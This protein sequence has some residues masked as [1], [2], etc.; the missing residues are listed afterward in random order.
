MRSDLRDTEGESRAQLRRK[1]DVLMPLCGADDVGRSAHS[2]R[3]RVDRAASTAAGS[4][5]QASR[6]TR[7]WNRWSGVARRTPTEEPPGRLVRPAPDGASR[8][9]AESSPFLMSWLIC[10]ARSPTVARRSASRT[11]AVLVRRRAARSPRSRDNVPT[12]SLPPSNSNVEAIEI[13]HRR[14]LG[15]IGQRPADA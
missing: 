3:T 13:E 4:W 12:S 8:C 10:R 2:G 1:L 9:A 15:K 14:L 5:S 6:D 7:C 11:R